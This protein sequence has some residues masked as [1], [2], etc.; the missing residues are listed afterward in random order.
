[1]GCYALLQGIFPTQGSNPHLLGLMCWLAS[2]LPFM[3]SPYIHMYIFIYMH[4]FIWYIYAYIWS[5]TRI[6]SKLTKETTPPPPPTSIKALT[7][8]HWIQLCGSV[9]GIADV[10][11]ALKANASV[12]VSSGVSKK[13]MSSSHDHCHFW[14]GI[15]L[16]YLLK[17]EPASL[18]RLS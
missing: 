9:C 6:Q 13:S 7:L 15:R 17:I 16:S 1:M 12:C 3:P 10:R 8:T 18:I 2:F 5:W 11:C 14:I 4:I